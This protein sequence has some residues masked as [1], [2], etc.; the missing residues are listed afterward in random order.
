M[1]GRVKYQTQIV[2]LWQP[3]VIY[4]TAENIDFSL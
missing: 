1:K 2:L 3:F 4:S